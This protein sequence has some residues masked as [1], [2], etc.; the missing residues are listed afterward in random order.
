MGQPIDILLPPI[1]LRSVRSIL[2]IAS[3][4]FLSLTGNKR[5]DQTKLRAVVSSSLACITSNTLIIYFQLIF[6]HVASDKAVHHHIASY[7]NSL[8]SNVSFH[9]LLG[10]C[11]QRGQAAGFLC[12][13]GCCYFLIV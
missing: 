8:Q 9:K 5:Q 12:L 4:P 13:H 11:R 2:G 6:A 7:L 10:I 3:L 1:F